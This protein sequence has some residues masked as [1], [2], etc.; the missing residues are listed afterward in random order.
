MKTER[1]KLVDDLLQSALELIPERREEFLRQEC[2]GD[3]A[4]ADEIRSLLTSHRRAGGFLQTPAAEVAARAMAADA[5][6]SLA[7]SR[8]GQLVSDY[9]LLKMIGSGGMGSVWLAERC[10]GRFERKVAIKFIHLAVLDAAGAER[11]KREGA[12]LGKLSHPQI[13]ELIDAGLTSSGEPFLALEYVEGQPIDAYCN[14]NKLS[15]DARIR[16]F[17]DVLS[18]VA[19]AHSNLIVHRDIKPTNVMIRNDA[20]VKLLDFG[21]AKV[22]VGETD[23]GATTWLT[24]EAGAA[25]TPLFA[26]PEQLNQ[27]TITTATDIYSLGVVLFMLLTGQH[28]AGPGPHSPAQLI[29]T[30]VD[31]E[32]PRASGAIS[33]AS[34]DEAANRSATPEKL[35]RQLRGDLDRIIAKAI[36]KTPAERYPSALAFADDLRRYLEHEPVLARPDSPGYRMA[37]FVRRNR[38]AVALATVAFI[39]LSAGVAWVV[40]QNR[41]VR[42][43][44]D[45][46]FHQLARIQEHDDFLDFLLSDAAPSG[47][48]FTVNDLLGRAA[49]IVEKQ[50]PSPTQI[51]LLDWIGVDYGS[52]DQ[53]A[54]A[55]PILERAYQL[56]R[57][58]PDPAIRATTSCALG[59]ALSRDEDLSRGDALIEEGLRE[60]PDDPQFAVDRVTC[61][62]QGSE[63]SREKGET[64][65]AVRRIETAQRVLRA[66][67]FDSDSFEMTVSL[68][69]AAVYSDAGKDQQALAEFQRAATLMTS[70]GRD[71]TETAVVLYNDWALELDQV[72]RPLEAEKIYRRVIDISRDNSTEEAVSP[73]VLNNYARVQRE[74]DHLP[75]AADY[76]ERAHAKALQTGDELVIN[77]SLL[78][79]ARIYRDQHDLARAEVMIAQV[80]PKLRKDLPPGHYAFAA[81]S[82]ERGLIAME[83]HDLPA[84]LRL[85]DQSI[86]TIQ[87]AVKAG[88]EG[89]F[90][91]PGLYT[92]RS[93]IDFTMGRADLAEADAE[94]ALTALRPDQNPG[95][96]SSKSGHAFLAQARALASE[97]KAAQA[98]ATASQALVQLQAS[99]GPDHPDTQSA[100]LLTQ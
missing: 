48:P 26:A 65:E 77:Q 29:K 21:I 96:I 49:Q 17:L 64:G 92:Y 1:W 69:L 43:E 15:V 7:A 59:F 88:G 67:P 81:I 5:A 19:H 28:P 6:P 83:K 9:R 79:L 51:E 11:F 14:E 30:I 71:E 45:F 84:A 23:I 8:A 55:R 46:A 100:R 35:R 42:A 37:K 58:S 90:S 86:A 76:A 33:S 98:R 54:M 12:I 70:L 93:Q 97:G 56:S 89:A 18:A 22:L 24:L 25:L 36:R 38:A 99:I 4:L 47:K 78:E 2:G 73:M 50:K 82:T 41:R 66:S 32:S 20:Q 31:Q 63:V 27:G 52:Q 75:Q 44:R 39:A 57:Q 53:H 13:A 10:D 60:L 16:L 68:D 61:L 94:H 95:D 72:G 85:I 34:T 91:L 87:A 62:R 3:P 40:I 80:E 74:L